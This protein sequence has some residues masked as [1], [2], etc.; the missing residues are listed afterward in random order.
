MGD[1]SW[2]KHL[3]QQKLEREH[4]QE[5][6]EGTIKTGSGGNLRRKRSLE[7]FQPVFPVLFI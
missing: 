7:T 1:F 3:R 6:R 4:K 2:G 5:R